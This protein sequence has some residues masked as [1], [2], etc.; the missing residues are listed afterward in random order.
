M[1]DCL[2]VLCLQTCLP[3]NAL[4][5]LTIITKERLRTEDRVV[6]A[7]A[8]NFSRSE[9]LA[10]VDQSLRCEGWQSRSVVRGLHNRFGLTSAE[11][12]N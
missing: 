7:A 2:R 12:D 5:F 11:G 6:S 3:Q 4:N 9:V 8:L 1:N 10:R